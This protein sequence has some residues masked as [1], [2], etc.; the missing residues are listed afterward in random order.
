MA[1]DKHLSEC[2]SNWSECAV[3]QGGPTEVEWRPLVYHIVAGVN[4]L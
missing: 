3:M 1:A 2:S 4:V